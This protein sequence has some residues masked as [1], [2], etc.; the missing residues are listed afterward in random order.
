MP[1]ESMNSIIAIGFLAVWMM[2][3]QVSF[4]QS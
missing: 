4:S 1:I 3:G 2:V